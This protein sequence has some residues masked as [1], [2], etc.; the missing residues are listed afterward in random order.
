MMEVSKE[1]S[2]QVGLMINRRGMVEQVIVG[3]RERIHI[4]ALSS[5]RV[6]RAR[7]RGLRFVHTHLAG[8]L[9]SKE[10]LTDLALLQLDFVACVLERSGEP[11][12][13]IHLGHLIP[14]NKKGQV[15]DFI[16]PMPVNELDLN[17]TEFITALETEFV[18]ERGTHYVT[19]AAG[20]EA[21]VLVILV[22]PRKTKNVEER[23]EELKDLSYSAG[24]SVLDTVVQRPK[25][26]PPEV[27][28]GKRK[29]RGDR[30]GR[31]PGRRRYA[32]LR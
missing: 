20:Q 24:L 7:F 11:A 27:S 30:H 32:R 29:D 1:V 28:G 25:E 22:P 6:G 9:L 23:I 3:T 26:L 16:G 18:R 31:P 15:W 21:C 19:R 12:E 17:F 14:E 10:D 13:L 5:E 4:P 2:R 8:E